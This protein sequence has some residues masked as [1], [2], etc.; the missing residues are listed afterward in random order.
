MNIWIYDTMRQRTKGRHLWL[1]SLTGIAAS[2]ILD[3]VVFFSVAFLQ[4]L[5]PRALIQVILVS[6]ATK[7]V[8]ALFITPFLYWSRKTTR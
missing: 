1:R 2:Q 3:S 4:V 8:H 5:P 6:Y 7:L